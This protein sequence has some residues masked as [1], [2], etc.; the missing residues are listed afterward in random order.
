L[1]EKNK[2]KMKLFHDEADNKKELQLRFYVLKHGVFRMIIKD[3]VVKR[4][5]VKIES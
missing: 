2:I 4:F 1:V 5:R 3:D